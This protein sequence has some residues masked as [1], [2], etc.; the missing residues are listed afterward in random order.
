MFAKYAKKLGSVT[1]IIAILEIHVLDVQTT[2]KKMISA[3]RMEGAERLWKG[4]KKMKADHELK[5]LP[6]YYKEICSHRKNFEIIKKDRDFKVGDIV[7]LREWD[8]ENYTG[9]HTKRKISYILTDAQKYGLQ[10][11]FCILALHSVEWGYF[12][13]QGAETIWR[14]AKTD[15]PQV[16]GLPV[17]LMAK[18]KYGQAVGIKAFPGYGDFIWYTTE[19]DFMQDRNARPLMDNRLSDKWEPVLWTPLPELP[20]LGKREDDEE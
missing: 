20:Y 15:P 16:A 9:H 12:R 3:N 2:M 5:I 11:R 1:V 19:S 6:E 7:L 10:D 13:Q 18:N 8:G 4:A 14:D 17:Y